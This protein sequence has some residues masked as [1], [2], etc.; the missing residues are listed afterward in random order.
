MK[1]RLILLV[2]ILCVAAAGMLCFMP[3]AYANSAMTEWTGTNSS[4][5]MVVGED[6][7]IVVRSEKLVFDV[8]VFPDDYYGISDTDAFEKYNAS[9]TATYEFYNPEDYSVDMRLMFPFGAIPTYMET[10]FDLSSK[11]AITADGEDVEKK[12][13]YSLSSSNYWSQDFVTADAVEKLRDD[14]ASFGWVNK[15]TIV[16]KR[17]YRVYG[18]K[19]SEFYAVLGTDTSSDLILSANFTWYRYDNSKKS[20]GVWVQNNGTFTV[21][22]VYSGKEPA[23]DFSFMESVDGRSLNASLDL[24]SKEVYTLKE[25]AANSN[26]FYGEGESAETD[27]FNIVAE[28]VYT[29][30]FSPY[31]YWG[32]GNSLDFVRER[33]ICWY[34]YDLH[35]DAKSSVVNSVSAPLFPSRSDRYEPSVYTYDYLLSPAKGWADFGTLD[36]EINTPYYMLDAE[37]AGFEKTQTGYKA[38][39][40]SLP[41]GELSFRL[42]ESKDPELNKDYLAALMWTLVILMPCL[43]FAALVVVITAAVV[44]GVRI[45]RCGDENKRK[46]AG[47]AV[48]LVAAVASVVVCLIAFLTA[49]VP[50]TGL[51]S[52][53]FGVNL[54]IAICGCVLLVAVTVGAAVLI[55]KKKN[56]YLSDDG[57]ATFD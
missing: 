41:D 21:Y 51:I 8:P 47:K 24:Q 4:G 38:H 17:V 48:A 52:L 13:R 27:W 36:I 2:T 28:A 49:F 32:S 43:C 46:R 9:V 53:K 55:V 11:Y 25:M 23:I 20:Y 50:I 16:E 7:P 3:T 10:G 19:E 42:C 33:V 57:I 12:V 45:G 29:D 35:V 18:A 44:C 54:A 15:D 39:Y 26:P 40:G 37:K 22:V 1:R 5:S 31:Y 56:K 30:T 34:E 6:C 14:Y